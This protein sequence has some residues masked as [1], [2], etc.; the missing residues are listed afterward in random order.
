MMV[1]KGNFLFWRIFFRGSI[2]F[3]VKFRGCIFFGVICTT[4]VPLGHGS[5]QINGDRITWWIM[6]HWNFH[7]EA[8][9]ISQVSKWWFQICFFFIPILGKIPNLTSIFFNWVET[10]NQASILLPGNSAIVTCLGWWVKTWPFHWTKVVCDQRLGI[11]EGHRLEAP[12]DLLGFFQ[13][14]ERFCPILSLNV[15]LWIKPQSV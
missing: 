15:S 7:R 6:I 2:W 3:H 4:D 5:N 12:G 13:E 11:S 14:N 8:D 9:K 10:T 1:S